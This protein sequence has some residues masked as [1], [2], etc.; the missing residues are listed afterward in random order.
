MCNNDFLRFLADQGG[1]TVAEMVAHFRVTQTAIRK[2]IVRLTAAQSITR[3]RDDPKRS[4]R[5]KY[6]YFIT[7]QGAAALAAADEGFA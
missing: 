3:K 2:R 7:S 5:P 1:H 6:L 4:G